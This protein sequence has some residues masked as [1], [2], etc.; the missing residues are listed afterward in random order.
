MI[1]TTRFDQQYANVG[2]LRQAKR[3]QAASGT[4]ADDNV[5]KTLSLFATHGR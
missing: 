4:R 1:A 2:V 3:Q 5:I